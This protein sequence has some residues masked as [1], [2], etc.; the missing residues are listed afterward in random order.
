MK[1]NLTSWPK[2][3]LK[4]QKRVSE[5][6]PVWM[7]VV[8]KVDDECLK[9]CCDG[10]KCRNHIEKSE[11]KSLEKLVYLHLLTGICVRQHKRCF[12]TTLVRIQLIGRVSSPLQAAAMGS[13]HL[14]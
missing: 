3:G 4:I 1:T 2:K 9:V 7:V 13:S 11:E 5:V 10:K 6:S 8:E 12:F 14:C